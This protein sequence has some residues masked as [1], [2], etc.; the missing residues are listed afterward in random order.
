MWSEAS[1]PIF[2]LNFNHLVKIPI[3]LSQIRPLVTGVNQEFWQ[4]EWDFAKVKVP[5]AS[6]GWVTNK[7]TEK[8]W[9][10]YFLTQK[11]RTYLHA[12]IDDTQYID[13]SKHEYSWIFKNIFKYS[14]YFWHQKVSVNFPEYS[15]KSP[16]FL[17][18]SKDL[19]VP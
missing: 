19:N 6:G 2:M 12:D 1:D 8:T 3:D 9:C 14:D 10:K 17:F 15:K 11:V 5:S 4:L 18:L 13:I 7:F 16:T